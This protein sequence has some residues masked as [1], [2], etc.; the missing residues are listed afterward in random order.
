LESIVIYAVFHSPNDLGLLPFLV[1]E[2][3]LYQLDY[4]CSVSKYLKLQQ[5]LLVV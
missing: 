5:L 2:W 4:A 1:V 3:E